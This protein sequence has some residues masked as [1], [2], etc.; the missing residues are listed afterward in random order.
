[1][2]TGSCNII[3][4]IILGASIALGA[5]LDF[6]AAPKWV[7]IAVVIVGL[8][9]AMSPR[10]IQEWE[11][12]VLLRLGRFQ[13][14][15]NPGV[16]WV[17][18]AVDQ[19]AALVDMRIRSTPFSAE[20]TLTQD[21][22]PVDVD[23]VLFWVVT[24]AKQAIL[25]VEQYQ[26]T[27]TWA[28]QTTLRDVIGRTELARMIS[29][30]EN[31]DTELQRIIDTKTADWGITVQSVEIRDVRI[32]SALEDAMSRKAQA[33]REKAARVILA[34]SET[35]VAAEM[36]KAA[37]VYEENVSAMRLRAMNMTYESIKERGALMVIPSG[38]NESMDPG[39]IG[40]AAAGFRTA[41]NNPPGDTASGGS[42]SG[43]SA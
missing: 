19:V 21:T 24:D 18:P 10:V 2:L 3:A 11:R 42:T 40:L 12:G 16:V 37:K 4:V 26:P 20:K 35:L 28:A 1:M 14:V 13:R 31:L 22:V 34:E 27:I 23:A 30:R 7:P 17:V 43:G 8:I 9:A 39:I 36:A 15:M 32:P 5:G 25:E 33:D 29:D 41:G 38:M 6:A